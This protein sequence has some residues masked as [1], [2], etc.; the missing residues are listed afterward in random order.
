MKSK[1]QIFQ[2]IFL[3]ILASFIIF[4]KFNLV[5]NKLSFDEV[6]FAKLALSLDSKPYSVYS[7]LATGHSTLY[8]YIILLSIKI[9]GITN[10]ALRFPSALF[11]ILNV[12]LFYFIVKKVFQSFGSKKVKN[13]LLTS[14]I[15]IIGMSLLSLFPLC[16]SF[17]FLSTRWFFS[18]PRFA[19]EVT[20]LLFLEQS[21]IWFFL[22]FRES[23]KILHLLLTAFLAGLA[24]HSYY[25]GRIFFLL[26]MTFLFFEVS[27]YRIRNMIIFVFIFLVT[28]LPLVS[29]LVSNQDIRISQELYLTNPDVKLWQKIEFGL[30]NII[31]GFFMLNIW[32]DLNGRHNYPGKPIFNPLQ[33]AFLFLGITYTILN[34]KK[35]YFHRFFIAYF[36]I[37]ILPTL[38]TFSWENPNLLRSFTI[39]PSIVYFMMMGILT[40]LNSDIKNGKVYFFTVFILSL[41]FFYSFAY[42]IR[43]YFKYQPK[44]FQSSF[45]FNGKINDILRL[46][47]WKKIG[48]L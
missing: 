20:F 23:K 3:I 10:F 13:K 9:F 32:A 14:K 45:E 47:L 28:I 33:V 34:Y 15:P 25:P 41:I 21:S 37:G 40:L 43:T 18:F 48:Y 7:T 44:V 30:V 42:D 12:L 22:R 16:A 31:K 1:Y 17:L 27:K 2:V 19:F 8:F 36:V 46:K 35:N 38:F 39:I 29:Y 6:E 24:F 4:Y 5:P 26:P 11:G